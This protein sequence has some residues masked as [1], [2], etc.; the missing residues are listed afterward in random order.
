MITSA[1]GQVRDKYLETS[2]FNATSPTSIGVLVEPTLPAQGVT[3][4]QREGD[5]LSIEHIQARCIFVNDGS[6]PDLVRVICLQ[7]RASTTLTISY[8]AAPTTGILD[9]GSSAAIDPTS[10]INWNAMNETFHVLHDRVYPMG[11][12]ASNSTQVVVLA[13]KPKVKKV[14]FTPGTTN[15]LCGG[16]F[17][18]VQ[19]NNSQPVVSIE[20]RLVYHDL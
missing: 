11:I 13:M 4:G 20:Q 1:M 12:S 16:I 8:A 9:L 19:T 3:N 10:M 7:A 17:W 15:P 6:T 5:S 18:I 2:V 14:N